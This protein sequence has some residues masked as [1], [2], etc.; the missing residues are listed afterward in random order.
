MDNTPESNYPHIEEFAKGLK[1]PEE[2]SHALY[3]VA[4]K[5][6]EHTTPTNTKE[7]STAPYDVGDAGMTEPISIDQYKKL[8]K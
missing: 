6:V 4:K 7:S 1:T 8:K 3:H 2:T 5:H